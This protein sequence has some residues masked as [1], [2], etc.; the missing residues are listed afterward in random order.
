M[1]GNVN[2]NIDELSRKHCCY[3]KAINTYCDES[4]YS[5]LIY[6][7]CN[8]RAPYYVVICGLS[9]SN[10]F[11]FITLLKRKIFGEKK[12][13]DIKCVFFRLTNFI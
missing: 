11:F 4:V 12:L 9:D 10:I 2:C 1:T 7:A 8:A 5:C 13:W 6:P 3:G